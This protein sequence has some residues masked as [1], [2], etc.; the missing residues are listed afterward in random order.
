MTT[1][2]AMLGKFGVSGGYALIY[3]MSAEL[4]PTVIRQ[5]ALGSCAIL[6]NLGAIIAPYIADLVSWKAV[7]ERNLILPGNLA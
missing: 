5:S 3:I 6:E 1:A 2:L 4:F 7:D